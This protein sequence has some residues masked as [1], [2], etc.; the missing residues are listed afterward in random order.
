MPNELKPIRTVSDYSA[1]L[2][3]VLHC[4]TSRIGAPEGDRPAALASL[5][6]VY[7]VRRRAVNPPDPIQAIRLRMEQLGLSRRDLEPMIGTS[8]RVSEILSSK[9]SLTIGMIRRLR[10]GLGISA[11]ILIEPSRH[12]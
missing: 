1:A 9:R 6:E 10:D 4:R 3:G 8:A 11:D 12:S 5:A 7:E 2:T